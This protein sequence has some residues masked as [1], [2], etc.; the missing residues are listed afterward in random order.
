KLVNTLLEH[1]ANPNARIVMGGRKS[2]LHT[3]ELTKI[4]VAG[5]TPFLLAA[6]AGDADVMRVLLAKGADPKI[7]TTEGVTPLMAAAGVGFSGD[8]TKEE[9]KGA[10]EAAK[11]LVELGADVNAASA[12]GGWRAVHGAAYTGSNEIL[13]FLVDKGAQLNVKNRDGQ[14]PL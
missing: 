3:S 13:Q 5:A 9:E 12:D 6:A 14:T 1:K 4:G 2:Q 11:L 8:R 7:A 10:L